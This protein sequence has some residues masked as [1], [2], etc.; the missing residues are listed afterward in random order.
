[1]SALQ[2]VRAA[3]GGD[4]SAAATL[5]DEHASLVRGM[6]ARRVADAALVDDL[7]QETWL[8]AFR[9]LPGFRGEAA[10]S[11]WLHSIVRNVLIS[12]GR[13]KSIVHFHSDLAE[14][15]AQSAPD[16]TELRL[17]LR[18]ALADLPD[19]MRQV[20]LLH[21]VEGWTHREIGATLGVAEGTS[22]SQL[23]KARAKL[24]DALRDA[25]SAV[26]SVA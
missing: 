10:F 16:P 1:M 13:R 22:K 26:V 20:L 7:C 18:R 15:A 12:S 23:F 4:E 21:D 14:D 24:R 3:A 19:G 5:Y 11:T 8:R 2:L 25:P 9:A 17:D 6:I